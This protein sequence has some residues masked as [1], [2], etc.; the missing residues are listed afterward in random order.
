MTRILLSM[1]VTFALF[2]PLLGAHPAEG[3]WRAEFSDPAGEQRRITFRFKVSQNRLD[4]TVLIRRE[5]LPIEDG[6]VRGENLSFQVT[7]SVGGMD[8]QLLYRGRLQG[9]TLHLVQETRGGT[10]ELT[11]QRV[12]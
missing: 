1:F 2:P 11:A 8:L 10:R 12:D 5:S 6:E 9:D 7:L 3:T 4:G